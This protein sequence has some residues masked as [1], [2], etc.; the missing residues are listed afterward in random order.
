[1]DAEKLER[2]TLE[3]VVK[4]TALESVLLALVATLPRHQQLEFAENLKRA[5]HRAGDKQDTVGPVATATFDETYA[6]FFALV[7]D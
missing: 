1:M 6:Q 2:L 3:N 7:A 4:A 5:A